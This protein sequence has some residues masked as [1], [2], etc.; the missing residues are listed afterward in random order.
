[1]WVLETEP[2]RLQEQQ[3]LW[4]TEH[5][6]SPSTLIVEIGFLTNLIW[7]LWLDWQFHLLC[8]PSTA[9]LVQAPAPGL[10]AGC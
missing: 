2:G 7:L 3:A 9:L 1:M 10:H 6:S 5:L 8:F 4:T